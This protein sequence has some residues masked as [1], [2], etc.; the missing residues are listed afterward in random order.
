MI[1]S[2]IWQLLFLA[3]LKLQLRSFYSFTFKVISTMDFIKQFDYGH[4]VTR[5]ITVF[6]N[7]FHGSCCTATERSMVWKHIQQ[8]GS[9][10][11][12]HTSCSW[13]KNNLM[14]SFNSVEN[15][16]L[17]AQQISIFIHIFFI[18]WGKRCSHKP[19]YLG[20]GRGG[21]FFSVKTCKM[22]NFTEHRFNSRL[23]ITAEVGEIK[24]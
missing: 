6:K 5:V 17:S 11:A 3:A 1:F 21:L 15:N 14:L 12:S 9:S 16:L 4:T 22:Y 18:E 8:W 20:E 24:L 13:C 7:S 19:R 23:S 10:L 2:Y